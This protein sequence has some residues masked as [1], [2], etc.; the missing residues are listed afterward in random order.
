MS[1]IDPT[2]FHPLAPWQVAKCLAASQVSGCPHSQHGLLA[3]KTFSFKN[4][5]VCW[6]CLWSLRAGTEAGNCFILMKRL[7][8]NSV[9]KIKET[10]FFF[11]PFEIQTLK[12]TVRP[13]GDL[14]GNKL[15]IQWPHTTRNTHS[16]EKSQMH[17]QLK[18]SWLRSRKKKMKWINRAWRAVRHHQYTTT[19]QTEISNL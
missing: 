17:A 6:Y 1:Q 14:R 13:L 8:R 16:L 10:V 15:E 18:L 4:L 11:S 5:S 9:K 12:E 19:Q 7:P 3:I 2:I